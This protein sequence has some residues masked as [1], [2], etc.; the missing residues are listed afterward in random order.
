MGRTSTVIGSI[1]LL[2]VAFVALNMVANFGLRGARIDATQGGLYTLTKGSRNIAKSS[3]EPIK[4]TYYY[5]AKL[6]AGQAQL[7][8][9][10]QRVRETLEEYARA[11]GGKIKLEVVDPEPFTEAEDR[12]TADGIQGIPLTQSENLYFGLVGSNSADGKEVIPFFDPRQEKLLEYNL[13]KLI[14][15]LSNPKKKIV[16][17]IAGIQVDGGFTMD[18]RTRQPTQ[19]KPWRVIADIKETFEVKNLGKDVKEIAPE[20]SVLLVIHP[21]ELNDGTLYAIDQYVMKGG[22]ALFFVDPNCD[23][24]PEGGN[25]M[26]GQPGSKVSEMEKILNAWGVEI[27]P[28]KFA[29]DIETALSVPAAQNSR[30]TVQAVQYLGLKEENLSREDPVTASIKTMNFGTAGVIR[31]KP[32][33]AV[34]PPPATDGAAAPPPPAAT[35][36]T[37]TITPMAQT[38]AKGSVMDA[39]ML[40]MGDP[41]TLLKS[42]VPGT[43][44]LTLAARLTGIVNSAFPAGRP[45]VEGE[46]PEDTAKYAKD[47]VALSK[48]PINVLLVA[49]VDCLAN[50]FW[51]RE[52]EVFPGMVI[53]QKF[54][55]NGDMVLSAVDNMLGSTDLLSVRA[56]QESSRPFTRVEDMQKRANENYQAQQQMLEKE[57]EETQRKINEL[58]VKKPGLDAFVLTPQQQEEVNKFQKQAGETRKKLRLVK[59]NLRKDIEKLGTQLKFINIGL[60]PVLVTLGAVGLGFYRVSRRRVKTD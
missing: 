19:T 16:G 58:Q 12:A 33:A 47:P 11:S 18:P 2:V 21:K 13:S 38:S 29:A 37:A 35:G 54:A 17:L 5:S 30:E 60:L 57:L 41:K 14:Y 9:Y 28:G 8:T 51:V 42:Y 52:Q 26:Q 7:Q 53:P 3:D 32:L 4:L 31:A 48:E 50:M 22:K 40:M 1:L 24:D 43:E 15:S 56:R 20:I 45:A 23:N 44:K 6:G 59:S 27:M 55:N 36:P 39:A 10:A 34:A 46:K 25:P 49:D